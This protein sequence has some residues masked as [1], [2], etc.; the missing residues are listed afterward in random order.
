MHVNKVIV[1]LAAKIARM[2]W[3]IVTKPGAMY[4]RREPAAA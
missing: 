4:V 3:V 2:A 1:A